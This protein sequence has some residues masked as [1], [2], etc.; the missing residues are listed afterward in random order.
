M[1][2]RQTLVNTAL[3]SLNSVSN[4]LRSCDKEGVL[5]RLTQVI[6]AGIHNVLHKTNNVAAKLVMNAM[7][8]CAS[9]Q[10]CCGSVEGENP[11]GLL[12]EGR[13]AETTA[14]IS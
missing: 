9:A 8:G 6:Q 11:K 10:V 1:L 5:G 7:L 14:F 13:E 3:L 12:W 2:N 4:W